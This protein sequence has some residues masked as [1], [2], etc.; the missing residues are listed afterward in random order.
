MYQ[1]DFGGY[2]I[3]RVTGRFYKLNIM[4]NICKNCKNWTQTTFFNYENV[5][6]SGTCKELKM[7]IDF[8]Y[9]PERIDGFVEKIETE[10]DFGCNLFEKI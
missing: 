1:V 7:K 4:I 5:V 9:Y 3:A 8:I 6:N 2:L 10:G